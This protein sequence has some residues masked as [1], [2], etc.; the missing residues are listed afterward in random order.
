MFARRCAA[1]R[2]PCNRSRPS[3]TVCN[4]PAAVRMRSLCSAKVVT[5]GGFK[6]CAASFRVAEVALCD[7][8]TCFA[9]CQKSFCVMGAILVRSCASL[10]EDEL[11]FRGRR[12]TLVT[13]IVILRGRRS[14]LNVWCVFFVCEAASSG[15][16]V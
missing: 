10:S 3:T 5:F 14:A 16:N 8:A 1:V 7:I 11:H 9:T 6:R 4:P 13:S 15:D 2:D 12:S